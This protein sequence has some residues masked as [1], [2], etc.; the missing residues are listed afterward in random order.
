KAYHRLRQQRQ[1]RRLLLIHLTFLL[2]LL[3]YVAIFY[4]YPLFYSIQISLEKYDLGAE[5][6]GVAEFIGLS[7]YFTILRD[8]TFQTAAFHTLL[9]TLLSI[10]PQFVLGL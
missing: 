3:L 10:V 7:N 6:T 2:P 8:P 9:F 5:I 4:G 1:T